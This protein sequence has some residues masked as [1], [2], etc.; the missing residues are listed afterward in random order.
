MSQYVQHNSQAAAP[1]I[2]VL[3]LATAAKAWTSAGSLHA[4]S[5]RQ[6]GHPHEVTKKAHASN[7]DISCVMN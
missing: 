4:K 2:C 7:V 6:D 3:F 1:S 5:F